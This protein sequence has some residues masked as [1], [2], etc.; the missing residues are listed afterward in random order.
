M[1]IRLANWAGEKVVTEAIKEVEIE[2]GN[3]YE[4]IDREALLTLME[5]FLLERGLD[6]KVVTKVRKNQKESTE[7]SETIVCVD[8]KAFM[9]RNP[10]SHRKAGAKKKRSPQK[11]YGKKRYSVEEVL[12]HITR[13]NTMRPLRK[14]FDGDSIK[15]SSLRLRTFKEKGCTCVTCGLEGTYFLKVRG[16][17]TERWHFNLYGDKQ[18]EENGEMI[19]KRVLFTKDHILPKSKGGPDSIDNMQTMCQTCNS[20]KG[21]STD[22]FA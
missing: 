14:D 12:P 15:M 13:R 22:A 3:L 16:N 19:D 1:N 18:V 10:R 8:N 6:V 7:K 20:R 2:E 4:D 21:N 17:P 9:K 5:F 11:E